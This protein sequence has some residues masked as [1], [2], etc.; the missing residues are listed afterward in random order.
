MFIFNRSQPWTLEE[1]RMAKGKQ[2]AS[3]HQMCELMKR[4]EQ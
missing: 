3:T 2:Q 4:Q 1:S